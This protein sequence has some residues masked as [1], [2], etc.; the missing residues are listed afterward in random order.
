MPRLI[1]DSFDVFTQGSHC[2]WNGVHSPA[3]FCEEFFSCIIDICEFAGTSYIWITNLSI[4][5]WHL[6]T[7]SAVG[8]MLN[9][10]NAVVT[11]GYLSHV[12]HAVTLPLSANEDVWSHPVRAW[13]TGGPLALSGPRI[14]T[15]SW[16]GTYRHDLPIPNDIHISSMARSLK[17]AVDNTTTSVS[18]VR[19][20]IFFVTVLCTICCV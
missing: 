18:T 6:S 3:S 17:M 9:S 4:R 10:L 16:I 7:V 5:G 2:W 15:S 14:V 8:V 11:S 13:N 20:L 19:N 12:S 1:S